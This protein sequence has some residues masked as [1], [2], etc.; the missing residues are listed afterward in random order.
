MYSHK[1]DFNMGVVC[2]K[3]VY[4]QYIYLTW[5]KLYLKKKSNKICTS[6]LEGQNIVID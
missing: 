1:V 4:I 3:F 2:V 5:F 6:I